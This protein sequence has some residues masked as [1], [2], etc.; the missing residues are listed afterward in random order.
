MPCRC[1]QHAIGQGVDVRQRLAMQRRIGNDGHQ[2]LFRILAAFGDDPGQIAKELHRHVLAILAA[3]L[4]FGVLRAKQLLRQPQDQRCVTV[5][6]AKDRG[7]HDQRIRHRDFLDEIAFAPQRFQL[8]D[9]LARQPG[10]A[11]PQGVQEPRMEPALR[12]VA[13]VPVVGAI[14]V[15][16]RAHRP[17][18]LAPLGN[19]RI[20]Y[21][22]RDQ[23]LARLGDPGL[24]VT[25][26]PLDLRL[27]QHG[28]EWAIGFLLNPQ[29]RSLLAQRGTAARHF[30]L[31]QARF[32]RKDIQLCQRLCHGQFP[33]PCG[34][35]HAVRRLA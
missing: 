27:A 18:P 26:D 16:Q 4:P 29:H 11:V 7:D 24:A 23:R 13:M 32:G 1:Q 19:D 20:L 22:A 15:E 2:I 9:I 5:W 17:G 8:V 33:F 21:V 25:L 6:Q 31:I 28:P 30:R 12:Q 35:G 14:H 34:T 3:A 10:H